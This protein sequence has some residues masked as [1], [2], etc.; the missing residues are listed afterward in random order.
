MNKLILLVDDEPALL[1]TVQENLEYFGLSVVTAANGQEALEKVK[2][3]PNIGM[4]LSDI[5]MP[6]GDGWFLL[7]EVKA[8]GQNFPIV[9][10]SGNPHLSRSEAL[11]LG[12]LELV[13]KPFN[14][15]ELIKLINRELST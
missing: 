5:Q 4:I 8:L 3:T 6:N 14:F 13:E 10:Y 7:K 1:Q 11:K 9:L 12:A 2:S 15:R